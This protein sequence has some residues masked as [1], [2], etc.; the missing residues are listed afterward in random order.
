[1]EGLR[2]IIIKG[3]PVKGVHPQMFT[4]REQKQKFIEFKHI[5]QFRQ[6]FECKI[7][8]IFL[9]ISFIICGEC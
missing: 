6:I 2:A 4:K 9:P 8:N 7:V 5:G 3:N 1:M